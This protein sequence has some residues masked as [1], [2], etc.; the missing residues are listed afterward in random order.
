MPPPP[1]AVELLRSYYTTTLTV[2]EYLATILQSGR[3][4]ASF[5]THETDTIAYRALLKQ[6]Y[7]GSQHAPPQA[8]FKAIPPMVSLRDVSDSTRRND[9][10]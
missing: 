4:D 3:K 10:S 9:T 1:L 7:V 8:K 2:Q 5:L 6:A